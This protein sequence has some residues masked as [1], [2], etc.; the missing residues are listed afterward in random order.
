MRRLGAR[1][2]VE[3]MSL[4]HHVANKAALLDGL[5]ERLVL[6]LEVTIDEPADWESTL[7]E[8]AR[9]YRRLALGHPR[10]FPLLT[11]R[12]LATP[13]ALVRTEPVFAALARAGFGPAER[14]V[15]VQT[16]VAFLNGYLLADVGTV[17]GHGDEPEPDVRGA[18]RA[19]DAT[20]APYVHAVGALIDDS[21]SLE[22]EF[23][24]SVAIVVEGFRR[25]LDGTI[26]RGRLG[27]RSP[28]DTIH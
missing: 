9:A 24:T 6:S 7:V 18:Y 21:M 19:V 17:P 26:T 16:F 3:A 20:V 4:Y 12:P 23:E 11:T 25:L 27:G 14:I 15:V 2:G 8:L 28:R 13:A 1:L 5:V 22:S 10:A